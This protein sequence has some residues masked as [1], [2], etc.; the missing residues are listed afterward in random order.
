MEDKNTPIR[1]YDLKSQQTL[2]TIQTL[3]ERGIDRMSVIVRHSD[4]HYHKDPRMEPFMGLTDTGKSYAL[5]MGK[6]FPAI[7]PR[8]FASH[9][10]RCIETAYLIDK[11]YT[12]THGRYPDP[13]ETCDLLAPFYIQDIEKAMVLMM[14]MGSRTFI[15]SW[16]NRDLD[17]GIMEDPEITTDRLCAF[18]TDR[19]DGLLGPGIAVCVSHDWNIFPIREFRLGLTHEDAGDVGY[20]DG[21]VFYRENGQVFAQTHQSGPTPV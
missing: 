10:G 9:F 5:D 18:M 17:P 1:Y 14:T 21:V 19:L 3:L 7:P 20:L 16:F 4:R 15:R 11:G 8:L 12:V 13:V 6:A 2:E